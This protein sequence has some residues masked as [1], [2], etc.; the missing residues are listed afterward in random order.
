[1][2]NNIST[3]VRYVVCMN[4]K[5]YSLNTMD[6]NIST[7]VRYVV[8]LNIKT[9][10]LNTMDNNISTFVRYVVCMNVKTYNLNTMDNNI[11][12]FVRY[13]VIMEV[14]ACLV[15]F[16]LVSSDIPYGF[17]S[18]YRTCLKQQFFMIHCPWRQH[19]L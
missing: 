8:C 7:F 18:F 16:L 10:N 6:N 13:V 14:F 3:F 2:D 1:M 17:E 15:P 4:V 12:T 9:Y 11:S 5:T 19:S